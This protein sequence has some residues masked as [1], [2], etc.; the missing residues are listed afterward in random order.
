[1]LLY[2]LIHS[3][4]FIFFAKVFDVWISTV[5]ILQIKRNYTVKMLTLFLFY[6]SQQQSPAGEKVS[7]KY[8]LLQVIVR[9]AQYRML[10]TGESSV[11][12]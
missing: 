7:L 11:N 1:M 6:L 10:L 9:V 3:T 12:I 2:N 5:N 4:I 8:Q